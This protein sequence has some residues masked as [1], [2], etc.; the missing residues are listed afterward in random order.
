M[1]KALAIGVWALIV[2][3]L[4]I[5]LT[6]VAKF[7]DGPWRAWFEGW[8]YPPWF[9]LAIGIAELGGAVTLIMKKFASYAAMLLI[10]IMMGALWTV[11]IKESQLGPDGPIIHIVILSLI[12]W[13][14]W[15]HR[16][17]PGSIHGAQPVV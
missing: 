13:G 5:G 1:Q 12:L 4:Q 10:G 14:R 9:L 8:G 7:G 17:R 15:K 11:T 2:F 3:E 6:G 16:W